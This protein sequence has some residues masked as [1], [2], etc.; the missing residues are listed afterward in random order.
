MISGITIVKKCCRKRNSTNV[1]NS[2]SEEKSY[3]SQDL[4]I[5]SNKREPTSSDGCFIEIEQNNL[6]SESENE[7]NSSQ[8]IDSQ[9]A[10]TSGRRSQKRNKKKMRKSQELTYLSKRAH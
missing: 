8:N 9:H 4:C 7:E 5:P 3:S 2:G 10:N 6:S 1:S